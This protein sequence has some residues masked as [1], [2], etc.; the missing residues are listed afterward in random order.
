MMRGGNVIQIKRINVIRKF[1]AGFGN[2]W[3]V[4]EKSAVI[5]MNARETEVGHS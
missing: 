1:S 4:G 2:P 3:V 5:N